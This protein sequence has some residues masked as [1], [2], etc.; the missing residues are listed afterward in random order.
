V[1]L[2]AGSY[3]ARVFPAVNE[4]VKK[5]NDDERLVVTVVLDLIRGHGPLFRA[6][7]E[8]KALPRTSHLSLLTGFGSY[9]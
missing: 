7:S 8:K 2:A 4:P 9:G 5:N 6:A 3:S 1:G